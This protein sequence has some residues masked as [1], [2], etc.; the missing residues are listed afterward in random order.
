MDHTRTS[1]SI[2][3]MAS[4]SCFV[5]IRCWWLLVIIIIII[6]GGL[7]RT[8]VHDATFR[9]LRQ[10]WILPELIGLVVVACH[11]EPSQWF[12]VGLRQD[13][14][15]HERRQRTCPKTQ[16]KT[17]A[18]GFMHLNWESHKIELTLNMLWY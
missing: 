18:T 2:I 13:T 12:V 11:K 5:G 9:V 10:N 1:Y 14:K 15:T 8:K 7:R 17:T 4:A 3:G 6:E 16:N